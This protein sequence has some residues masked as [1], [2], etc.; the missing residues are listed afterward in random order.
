MFQGRNRLAAFCREANRAAGARI[1][2]AC[3][4]SAILGVGAASHALAQPARDLTSDAVGATAGVFRVD[5]SGNATYRIAIAVPPGTAGVAPSLALS[6]SSQ[7]APGVMSRGWSIEGASS[8]GRCR[9]TREHGDFQSGGLASDGNALPVSLANTDRFC[10]DGQRLLRV[11]AGVDG[12]ADTVYYPE[13]DPGTRVTAIGGN[14]SADPSL[15]T[16]PASFKVERRD[17]TVSEY[18]NSNDSRI[19]R[20]ACGGFTGLACATSVWA[21]NRIED[22]TGNYMTWHYAKYLDGA[23]TSS[24]TG[25]DEYVLMEVR[26]TGKRVLTG[27]A[28][29]SLSPYARVLFVYSAAAA[30]EQQRGWLAGSR[31]ADASSRRH[32]GPG[33]V[34]RYA[35]YRA[36]LRPVIHRLQLQQPSALARKRAGMQQGPVRH[37]RRCDASLLPGHDVRAKHRQVPVRPQ[38]DQ[39]HHIRHQ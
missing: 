37:G 23:Q 8:I 22:S 34:L 18:G 33:S 38:P 2:M 30:T 32:Q 3:L 19:E 26:Y 25:A 6:Y 17:G 15:Y 5:E 1:A 21:L 10:L 27:Q 11:G 36:P 20:N 13:L 4:M 29:S 39:R 16:G 9:Q 12:G 31:R 28:G 24:G 35:T 7:G 14:N